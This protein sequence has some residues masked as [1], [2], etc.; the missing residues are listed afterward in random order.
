MNQISEDEKRWIQE[1]YIQRN[2]M[3]ENQR[4]DEAYKNGL[5][6]G[7]ES[8]LKKGEVIGL[9][10]GELIGLKSGLRKAVYSMSQKG[11]DALDIADLLDESIEVVQEIL[12]KE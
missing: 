4:I 1:M 6:K 8:G 11:M 10:K 2:E 7:E 3:D 12:N 5:K 9:K